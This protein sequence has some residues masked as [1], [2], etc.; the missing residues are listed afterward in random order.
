MQQAE[1]QQAASSDSDSDPGPGPK[2][3]NWRAQ[4]G[5]QKRRAI[6]VQD[7]M[8]HHSSVFKDLLLGISGSGASGLVAEPS[9]HDELFDRLTSAEELFL[10]QLPAESD[11][12]YTAYLDYSYMGPDRS[13][14]KLLRQYLTHDAANKP[15]LVA[16]VSPYS[17]SRW[18]QDFQWIQRAR[19]YDALT[20]IAR[21]AEARRIMTTGLAVV[22]ERLKR[23]ITLADMLE[24]QIFV[25]PQI[26]DDGEIIEDEIG[27]T[28]FK[29]GAS[30]RIWLREEHYTKTGDLVTNYKLN[31]ALL[32][33]YRGVLADIAEEVGGRKGV[34]IEDLLNPQTRTGEAA[35]RLV[36]LPQKVTV[37][38]WLATHND[39]QARLPASTQPA[40]PGAVRE[41]ETPAS[42]P[43]EVKPI[44]SEPKAPQATGSEDT[45]KL[46]VILNPEEDDD[47]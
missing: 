3:P 37:E 21:D 43:T 26:T 4:E 33:Q 31:A 10:E 11:Q 25:A 9:N 39:N 47:A 45:P 32:Q 27:Q 16:T 15:H 2:L 24:A 14:N 1:T 12:A 46:E 18:C 19:R 40:L 7:A 34:S 17:L 44:K 42:G 22:H 41:T 8:A 29:T 28:D 35:Q 6:T 30:T 5:H 23:L 36:I 38:A 20:R 13:V